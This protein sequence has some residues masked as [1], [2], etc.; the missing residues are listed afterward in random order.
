MNA[1]AA[2]GD[3]RVRPPRWVD[4]LLPLVFSRRR[5]VASLLLVVTA[6]LAVAAAWSAAAWNPAAAGRLRWQPQ[7]RADAPAEY[8]PREP[9]AAA[10]QPLALSGIAEKGS[11]NHAAIG[12]ASVDPRQSG[13]GSVGML[14]GSVPDQLAD[15]LRLPLR[16]RLLAVARGAKGIQAHLA[17]TLGRA[18]GIAHA[19]A[20]AGGFAACLAAA[21]ALLWLC[22]GNARQAAMPPAAAAIAVVWELGLAS[23]TGGAS[24]AGLDPAAL[25]APALVLAVSLLQGMRYVLAWTSDAAE[26]D[27]GGFEAAVSAWR[28]LAPPILAAVLAAAACFASVAAAPLPAL[29]ALA[30][31]GAL[32][33]PGIVAANLVLLPIWLSEEGTM[34]AGAAQWRQRRLAPGWRLLAALARPRLAQACLLLSGAVLG[35]AL[36]Q[37]QQPHS[38]PA[39]APAMRSDAAAHIVVQAFPRAAVPA[40]APALA[41]NWRSRLLLLA[42]LA[43]IACGG[44]AALA[45][46]AASVAMVL[47]PVLAAAAALALPGPAATGNAALPL[48]ALAAAL[49]IGPALLLCAAWSATRAARADPR[50]GWLR[51]LTECGTA[52]L[53][54]APVLGAGA[55]VW[56]FA[57]LPLQRELG[58]Q[59]AI[60][61][62]IGALV[63]LAIVPAAVS[64]AA[65]APAPAKAHSI[66]L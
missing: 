33:V 65:P 14:L 6:V 43:A 48:A 21:F 26:L 49:A 2:G 66:G 60:L 51:T 39:E 38:L 40:L 16:Q 11:A 32:G 9:L 7:G 55:A 58:M 53:L 8:L 44:L 63:A 18:A 57:D 31:D 47:T 5:L 1:G 29:R 41:G 22:L 17:G 52:V 10:R 28:R 59:M 25:Y 36:W 56:R 45:W 24:P 27:S 64:L 15:A 4:A 42:C 23:L 19:M 50:D 35:W 61:G 12:G 13:P 46:R 34:D 20:T 3:G 30:W 54:S 62:A 37:G